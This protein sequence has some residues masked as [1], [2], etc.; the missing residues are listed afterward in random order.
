MKSSTA[1]LLS[2]LS[3]IGCSKAG[4]I[5]MPPLRPQMESQTVKKISGQDCELITVDGNKKNIFVT[6]EVKD[7]KIKLSF[8]N[9]LSGNTLGNGFVQLGPYTISDIE[10]AKADQQYEGIGG[11]FYN[12]KIG[13]SHPDGEII[14]TNQQ[15]ILG[16]NGEGEI[17][18]SYSLKVAG[19]EF[20]K[21]TPFELIMTLSNCV[22][23]EATEFPLTK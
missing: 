19:E 11:M 7:D 4:K 3:C 12:T 13:R 21:A 23:F 17:K 15:F 5:D 1:L 10:L 9:L 14:A 8:R 6:R 2:L 16:E 22:D 20:L 18:M